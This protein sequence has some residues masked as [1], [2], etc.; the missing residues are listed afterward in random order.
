[1]G[2][3]FTTAWDGEGAIFDPSWQVRTFDDITEIEKKLGAN[4]DPATWKVTADPKRPNT[5]IT[6]ET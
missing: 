6:I 1:M 4:R 2:F 3:K 5:N